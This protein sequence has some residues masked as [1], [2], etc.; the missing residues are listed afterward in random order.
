MTPQ[1]NLYEGNQRTENRYLN[2]YVYTHVHRCTVHKSQK[3]E[4][5]QTPI[6]WWMDK[7]RVVYTYHTYIQQN[8]TEPLKR[9][10]YSY[11]LQGWWTLKTPC[12][13]KETRHKN[14]TLHNSIYT[15][16]PEYINL[17]RMY[18]GGYQWK[19]GVERIGRN[20]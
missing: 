19:S 13:M 10:E 17:Y 12:Q 2:K 9:T 20:W 5:A 3:V 11:K 6:S 7:H 4:T 8:I 18:I 14:L 1:F 16:Y 15:K